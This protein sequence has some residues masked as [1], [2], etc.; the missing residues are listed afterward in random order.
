MALQSSLLY[1]DK[2]SV[3]MILFSVI[4]TRL[5]ARCDSRIP[6]G[7]TNF[8]IGQVPFPFPG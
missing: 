8:L 3:Q 2:L 5:T 6:R 4:E 7:N 1:N